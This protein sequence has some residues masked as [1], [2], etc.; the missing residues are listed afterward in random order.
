MSM[1]HL[2]DRTVGLVG[3]LVAFLALAYFPIPAAI[4][5]GALLGA[6]V[7]VRRHR[8][9]W[10]VLATMLLGYAWVCVPRLTGYTCPPPP[11]DSYPSRA[12]AAASRSSLRARY[13]IVVWMFV[14]P[15][16]SWTVRMSTPR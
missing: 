11:A 6:F 13:R 4:G 3:G 16:S 1:R 10:W 14:C 15:M 12:T 8:L 5:L 7:W 2:V 9:P